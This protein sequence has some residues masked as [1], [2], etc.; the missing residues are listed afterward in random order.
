MKKQQIELRLV[1][2]PGAKPEFLAVVELKD[3]GRP[4]PPSFDVFQSDRVA[5][6]VLEGYTR[7][8][9]ALD[10][11][12]KWEVFQVT[13]V[14]GRNKMP[15]F[16]NHL[17]E[18]K[19]TAFG[20]MPD[21][22]V[23][24]VPHKQMSSTTLTCRIAAIPKIPNCPLKPLPA[25]AAAAKPQAAAP[26]QQAAAAAAPPPASNNNTNTKK[27][28]GFGFLG[29]LVGAQKRTNQQVETVTVK[30][31]LPAETTTAG[32]DASSSS[33]TAAGAAAQPGGGTT[34]ELKTAGQVLAEFRQEMEQQMLDFDIAPDVCLKVKIDVG[35]KL[36]L[37]TDAE[38]QSG[39]ITME[40]LKYIVY[41]QAEEVNEEWIA[42]KE[43]S[44]F[45][46]EVTI[47]IYK[48]GEAP[49]EV[50]EDINKAELPDEVRGQQ[51]AIQQ[52][53]QK[54]RLQREQKLAK[55]KQAQALKATDE[56]F[57]VLNTKKRDRRTIEDYQRAAK[58]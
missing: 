39:R 15:G 35:S 23:W 47:A 25:G 52:E 57:A 7:D 54:A 5:I 38:K 58:R 2:G 27:K 34:E 3:A 6:I 42:H 36:K 40:I 48:E 29:N 13:S 26:P 1:P 8:A 32:G 24:V 19:K 9:W 43:Q 30:K 31:S 44:E 28:K 11:A 53:Q 17:R 21:G 20:R 51:L 16:V 50:M 56:D 46:D 55:F 10:T 33:S 22:R 4:P 18:R 45:M 12:T 41:E 37:L 14:D 49:P